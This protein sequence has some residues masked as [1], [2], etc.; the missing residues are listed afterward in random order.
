LKRETQH[1]F[2]L[3]LKRLLRL[4]NGAVIQFINGLF[5]TDHP[6]D[7]T[8]EYPN[9]EYVSRKLR[10]LMSDI[11]VVINGVN[12]YHLEAEIKDDES[13]VI[14]IFEYGFAQGLSTKTASEGGERITI[15]FPN[16]R[17]I[18]WETTKRTP[19]EVVLTLEFPDGGSYD[20]AVTPTEEVTI[21]P[22]RPSSFWIT[23]SRNLKRKD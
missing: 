1:I 11:V 6:L 4:S 21:M 16:A 23:G 12:V 18:Y 20:Y 19:D 2:D 14:R 22:S 13:I 9:T 3:I 5:G 10:R 8:V 17:I 15:K 7:S